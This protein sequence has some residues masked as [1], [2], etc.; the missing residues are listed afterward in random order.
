M[1]RKNFLPS[2][3]LLV[4][5]LPLSAQV[6][7]TQGS[8]RI[9]VEIDGKPFTDFFI[10]AAT[11][12]PYL[13]PLRSASGKIITRSYPMETVEGE[14][15]D[16]PH[17]RGLWFTHGL[18]NGYDF[19]ANEPSQKGAS[20]SGKGTVVIRKVNDL[21]SGKKT[22]KIVT[23]FDW[24]GKDG[25]TL[26]QERRTMTF[27]SHPTERW[28][29]FDIV[30]VAQ[31]KSEFQDT[32]E[33]TFAIRLATELEEKHTGKMH[34]ADGKEGEKQVWGSRSPWVDYAGMVGGEALGIAIFDHP[35]NPRHPTYWHS[36]GYGLFAANPFGVR[37]FEND[38]TK[39]GKLEL[40]PG[41]Q[42][43]FRYRV[44]IHPGNAATGNI[45]DSYKKFAAMK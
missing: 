34:S 22:G 9:L 45:A 2:L 26:L 17:H 23:T 32:K 44:V 21:Q 14:A 15:K 39:D 11:V 33:G 6:K 18:V 5:S 4:L 13:H 3:A 24:Q 35:S 7:I 19:W 12:K 16:H 10:G 42:L 43:R 25:K 28:I 31:E 1:L 40:G 38:K 37:D 41:E 8:D 36:R 27:Y 20:P 29:D 30:L